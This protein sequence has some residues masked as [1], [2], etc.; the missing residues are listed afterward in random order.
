VLLVNAEFDML[1]DKDPLALACARN[2][3]PV[4][5]KGLTGQPHLRAP[6]RYAAEV[7]AFTHEQQAPG[8]T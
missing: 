1:A 5:V 6:A 7:T 4:V 2:A 3:R 8:V